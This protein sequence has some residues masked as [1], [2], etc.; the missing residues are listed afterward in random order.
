MK[1]VL[2]YIKLPIACGLFYA[3]SSAAYGQGDDAY[4]LDPFTVQATEGY[5][6]TNTISGTGLSTPLQNVPMAINIITSDFLEDSHIGEFTHAMDYNA[7]IT[8]TGR[9]DN[10]NSVASTFAIRGY[11][12]ST[13]LVDGVL[14]GMVLPMQMI[15]RIEV[16]KGPNTLYGQAEPS[17]LINVITKTPRAEQGGTIRAITGTNEWYQ[18]KLDYTVRAMDDKLGLRIMTDNKETNGWRW[19]DNRAYQFKGMSGSYELSEATDID[20]LLAENHATG[21]PTQRATWSFE[22]IPTDLN[23]DGDTDDTVG[24]VRESTA[25][26]NNTFLP[27]EYVSS[28]PGNTLDQQY[29]WMSMGIRHSFSDNHNFQYKYNFNER[30]HLMSAREFNTFNPDGSN[31]VNNYSNEFISR[32]EVH[33]LN[34]IIEFSTGEV[35][36]QLLLGVRKS[37]SINNMGRGN[38]RLRGGNATENAAMRVIEARTGKV[39][40]DVLYREDILNGAPIWTDD[41]PTLEEIF[42]YGQRSNQAGRS[43]QDITTMYATDNIYFNNGQSNVIVGIRNIDMDQKA[44]QTNPLHSRQ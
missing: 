27:P 17:G 8:Q 13:M 1:L 38:Y 34:D 2:N 40:R 23:G 7:S 21:F 37:E 12:N 44:V 25:R 9:N 4:T 31:P 35:K 15:D 30:D 10:G 33:T 41:V 26:F 24:G 20:F 32:D 29:Y 22:R 19:L 14:G 36:H 6:A 16:V 39:F 43:F 3:A 28:G 18:L 5:T 42:A 11:R